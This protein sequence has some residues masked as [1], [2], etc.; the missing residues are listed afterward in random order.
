[1]A[2]VREQEKSY[3][4]YI[5]ELNKDTGDEKIKQT[6]DQWAYSYEKVSLTLTSS[7]QTTIKFSKKS[8]IVD[9]SVANPDLQV[10]GR[11]GRVGL[12]ALSD[13]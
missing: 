8:R 7:I 2:D 5:L 4:N 13:A 6:F 3:P 10:I 11:E 12:G 1:M 9:L